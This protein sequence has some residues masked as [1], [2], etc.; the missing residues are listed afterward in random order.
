MLG[1]S[2]KGGERGGEKVGRTRYDSEEVRYS[3]KGG[4]GAD[5]GRRLF[6]PISVW[7]FILHRAPCH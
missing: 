3:K 1:G 7:C 6:T 4:W 5:R 2:N